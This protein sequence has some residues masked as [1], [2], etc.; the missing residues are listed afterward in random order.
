MNRWRKRIEDCKDDQKLTYED[1]AE[2]YNAVL[3]DVIAS[4]RTKSHRSKAKM[5]GAGIN[6]WVT[7]I[8][9]PSITQFF[10]LAKALK[11]APETLLFGIVLGSRPGFSRDE[12]AEVITEVLRA[13][14]GL[15][16]RPPFTPRTV[17]KAAIRKR[18]KPRKPK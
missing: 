12:V 3:Q 2:R 4:S 7:G 11:V 8:R 13:E 16:T 14:P 10:A 15:A 6:H 5:K 9:E 18:R 1:V 17:H